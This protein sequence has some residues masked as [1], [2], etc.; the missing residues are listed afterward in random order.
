MELNELIESAWNGVR[1]ELQAKLKLA[2]QQVSDILWIEEDRIR[3]YQKDALVLSMGDFAEQSLDL[4]TIS[5][6]FQKHA[7]QDFLDTESLNRIQ[8]LNL[9]LQQ[10]VREF[11]QRVPPCQLTPL[12]DLDILKGLIIDHLNR[13]AECFKWMRMAWLE[14][15][16]KYEPQVHDRFFAEFSWEHLSNDEVA[17]CPPF[18]V[19]VVDQED[20]QFYYSTLLPLVTSGLPVKVILEKTHFRN[21]FQSFSRSTALRCSLEIEMLPIALKGV[22]VIQD[23]VTRPQTVEHLQKGLVSPRPGIFSLLNDPDVGRCEQAVLSRAFPLFRYDPDQS[24]VFLK[25]FSLNENPDLNCVW[26]STELEFMSASGKK[27]RLVKSVTFADFAAIESQYQNDFVDLPVEQ[28]NRAVPVD[29]YLEMRVADRHSKIPYVITMNAQ[30]ELVK[31][32]PSRRII[33]QTADKKHLWMSLCEMAGVHNPYLVEFE[34]ALLQRAEQEKLQALASLRQ[35]ILGTLE[36]QKEEAVSQ[37]MTQLASRLAG[38]SDL[39][40]NQMVQSPS[41]T[42]TSQTQVSSAASEPVVVESESKE[43]LDEA[44]I[45]SKLCTGCDECVTI[46][47]NVFAYNGDKQAYVKNPRGGP[48]KNILKASKKCSARII[49]PGKEF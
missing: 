38:L 22:Y 6:V 12:K 13:M 16:S 48:Y 21:Q 35:E 49:H 15:Q 29:A 46:E 14:S 26:S 37:A 3:H 8:S 24:D 11:D 39:S 43:E 33:A 23:T 19:N 28:M 18:V 9:Q 10:W 1:E 31:K 32:V 17:L 44:W 36:Q 5:A 34:Q 42:T 27:D 4:S 47:P 2:A 40:L 25:R 20:R 45:E 7:S 41:S 30:G